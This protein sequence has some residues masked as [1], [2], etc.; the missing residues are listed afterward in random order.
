MLHW[1]IVL[2]GLSPWLCF[3]GGAIVRVRRGGGR[4]RRLQVEGSAIILV[5]VAAKWIVFSPLLGLDTDENYWWTYWFDRAE[6]GQFAIG[7]LLFGLGYFLDERP[8][9]GRPAW[10]L[11]G[12]ALAF[13]SILLCAGAGWYLSRTVALPWL[14]LPWNPGRALFMLGFLP[15][16]IGYFI[17]SR[18]AP[19]RQ[20]PLFPGQD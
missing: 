3:M 12:K 4:L 1:L 14:E 11:I 18:R 17:F 16:A 7:L 9:P 13:L 19:W 5:G 20:T 8:R 15:A 2:L 10:P 6:R